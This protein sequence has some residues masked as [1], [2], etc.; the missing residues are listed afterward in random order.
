VCVAYLCQD[1]DNE[2]TLK[3]IKWIGCDDCQQWLHVCCVGLNRKPKGRFSCGCK[4]T[5]SF[6]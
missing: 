5:F 3:N 6:K 4:R 2:K 1:P